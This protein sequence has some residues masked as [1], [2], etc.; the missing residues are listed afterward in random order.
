MR[1]CMARGTGGTAII[2][3][4]CKTLLTASQQMRSTGHTPML[5][6]LLLVTTLLSTVQTVKVYNNNCVQIGSPEPM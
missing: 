1:S 4:A 5:H 6:Q 3:A 2:T